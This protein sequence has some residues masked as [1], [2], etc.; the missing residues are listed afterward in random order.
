MIAWNGEEPDESPPVS[1]VGIVNCLPLILE[2]SASSDEVRDAGLQRVARDSPELLGLVYGIESGQAT[3]GR[4]SD[5]A[6]IG[7][8]SDGSGSRGQPAREERV[9]G[10]RHYYERPV[11]HVGFRDGIYNINGRGRG[12][13]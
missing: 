6:G 4:R 13:G 1:R 10:L 5:D 9:E 3:V 8:R 7:G 12:L 2:I 11:E